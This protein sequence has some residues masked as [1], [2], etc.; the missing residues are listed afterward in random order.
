MTRR[1]IEMEAG[2]I[3]PA[4][5]ALWGGAFEKLNDAG[6]AK[7]L[8]ESP[9]DRLAFER[10]WN[11]FVDALEQAWVR[12]FDEGKAKFSEFQPWAGAFDA[13]RKRDPLLQYLSQARHQSQHGRV[14]IEWEEGRL[15]IAPGFNGHL[16][17]LKIYPDGTFE[18]D[19]TPLHASLPKA[20]VVHSPGRPLLPQ[21]ENKRFK[22]VFPPPQE[23]LGRKLTNP[24]PL[25]VADLGLNYYRDVFRAGQERWADKSGPNK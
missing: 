23:H 18:M 1:R 7:R 25:Q 10:S 20:R 16:R 24:S 8:M 19:A 4:R 9:V 14:A 22:Q 6:D 5:H 21:I 12:F 11:L 2:G 13:E 17:S 3:F 15:Q